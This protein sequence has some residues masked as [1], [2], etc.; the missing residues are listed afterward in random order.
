MSHSPPDGRGGMCFLTVF[1]IAFLSQQL[2]TTVKMSKTLTSTG[3]SLV[4][5]SRTAWGNQVG[6]KIFPQSVNEQQVLRR[7]LGLS[8][9]VCRRYKLTE[10]CCVSM[11]L[12][13][14]LLKA[15]IPTSMLDVVRL[16]A[17]SLNETTR[18]G[19]VQPHKHHAT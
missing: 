7:H 2:D 13:R 19:N 6:S 12:Q 15:Y 1:N 10:S 14:S 8:T 4:T 5:L 18:C 11:S 17:K 9:L 3:L 16:V